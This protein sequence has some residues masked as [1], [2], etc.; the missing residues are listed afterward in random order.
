M[1]EMYRSFTQE[2]AI[3]QYKAFIKVLFEDHD[4]AVIWHCT[5]GKDRAGIATALVEKLLGVAEEDIIADYLA[6]NTYLER[7]IVFLTDMIKKEAKT[8]SALADESLRYIF[9]AHR[10]YIDAFYSKVSERYG[11]LD[12]FTRKGLGLSAD[13]IMCLR[14]KYLE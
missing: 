12:T 6:T 7:D 5:A 14:D 13:D 1:C 10:E 4:K 3:S 9:G 8:D 11:D 2:S